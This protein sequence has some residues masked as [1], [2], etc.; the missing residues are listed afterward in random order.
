MRNWKL[1]SERLNWAIEQKAQRDGV[2]KITQAAIAKAS[3]KSPAA[4]GYWF[5]DTNGMDADNARKVGEFLGVDPVWLETGDG[6]PR[7]LAPR[8]QKSEPMETIPI[9]VI[10][11]D[12]QVPGFVSIPQVTLRLSAGISHV[13]IDHVIEDAPPILLRVDWLEKRGIN[14][15]TLIATR[16][17]GESMEPALYAGDVVVMNTADK[18]PKDGEVYAINYEGEDIVKRLLRD[19]GSWYLTSD[20][21]DKRRYP[22]K[23]CEGEMCLIIGKIIYKQSER[24]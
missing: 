1:L 16:V 4:V 3:G 5:A 11:Q 9:H 14:P 7:R 2:K 10:S 19:A 21:P 8:E 17:K 24:I 12:D 6:D 13:A 23:R 20:N 18:A 22:N 15:K